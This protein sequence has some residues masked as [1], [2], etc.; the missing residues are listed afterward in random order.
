MLF[1]CLSLCASLGIQCCVRLHPP[2]FIDRLISSVSADT[3]YLGS[4]SPYL[5]AT[6]NGQL[7]RYA[8][9]SPELSSSCTLVF[10]LTPLLSA[11]RVVTL[12]ATAFHVSNPLRAPVKTIQ[13]RKVPVPLRNYHRALFSPSKNQR[14]L[15][16]P[17]RHLPSPPTSQVTTS[18]LTPTSVS[19]HYLT[20]SANTW[21]VMC[22]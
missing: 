11:I 13:P 7:S 22:R 17:F 8:P 16:G 9:F 12:W 2:K 6:W 5:P 18:P 14:S 10:R 15:S 3:P 21:L 19:A 1:R 20:T 4:S